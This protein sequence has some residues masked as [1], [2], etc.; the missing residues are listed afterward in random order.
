MEMAFFHIIFDANTTLK[1]CAISLHVFY[2]ERPFFVLTNSMK[3]MES[4]V[5]KP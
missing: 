5:D 3:A 1:A 2:R 4:S